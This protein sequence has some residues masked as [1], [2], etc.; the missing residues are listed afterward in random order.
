MARLSLIL[1]FLDIYSKTRKP[2]SFPIDMNDF[3]SSAT[4]LKFYF[5]QNEI[6]YKVTVL[7][8]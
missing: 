2:F 6:G 3:F 7:S 5:P 8:K 1:S 4:I